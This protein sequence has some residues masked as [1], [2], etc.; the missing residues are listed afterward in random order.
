[1]TFT[2]SGLTSAVDATS[3]TVNPSVTV[4]TVITLAASNITAGSALFSG[5]VN[6]NGG[7]TAYWFQYGA[8][9]SY[10]SFTVTNSASST[11]TFGIVVPNLLQGRTYHYQLVATNSAGTGLGGDIS[12]NTLAV[13]PTQFGSG[14][15]IIS[16]GG[17]VPFQFSFTNTPGASFSVLA[18]TN[19]AL[20]LNQW[21]NLGSAT[22]VSPGN[23]Q[24]SDPNATNA[25][26]FY[27][28]QTQ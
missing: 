14:S 1:L 13:T 4:P 26:Q 6:P 10:G 23:Y 7:T 21:S 25:A 9:T 19:V 18:T 8:N 5:S 27:I 16:G 20:P 28:L 11:G 22:E 3:I 15:G 24:F 2:A 12:F 17:S